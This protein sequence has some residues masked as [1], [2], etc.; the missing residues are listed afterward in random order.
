MVRHPMSLLPSESTALAGDNDTGVFNDQ[1]RGV[2]V[3]HV[4]TS[5]GQLGSA[6][7]G[8]RRENPHAGE[9]VGECHAQ[10]C[11]QLVNGPRQVRSPARGASDPRQA[12]VLGGVERQV[13]PCDRVFER[14]VQHVVDVLDGL[15]RQ[16]GRGS[17]WN[18]AT[19]ITRDRGPG[20][21]DR[22]LVGSL[23]YVRPP[24]GW[25][26]RSARR[27]GLRCSEICLVVSI[28]VT[29]RAFYSRRLHGGPAGPPAR[30]RELSRTSSNLSMDGRLAGGGLTCP[31]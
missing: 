17:D 9:P 6:H 14:S 31:K 19:L 26:I 30:S 5:A 3:E 4:A 28:I 27:Q 12:G 18:T 20:G 11:G 25:Y 24:T 1:R 29:K 7:P 22:R 21:M 13:I 10:P 8:C 16:P 2:V 15:W 23:R